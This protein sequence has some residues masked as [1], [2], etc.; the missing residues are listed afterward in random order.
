MNLTED[1][2]P[3]APQTVS[4]E[5][6]RQSISPFALDVVPLALLRVGRVLYRGEQKNEDAPQ[7]VGQENWRKISARSHARHALNHLVAWLAGHRGE[8]HLEH[9][10]CRLLM[11]IERENEAPPPEPVEIAKLRAAFEQAE[12]PTVV[13]ASGTMKLRSSTFLVP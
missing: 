12:A 1:L 7:L 6:G 8:E 13:T 3:G 2:G 11:A 5:G 4:P 10:V 9:A